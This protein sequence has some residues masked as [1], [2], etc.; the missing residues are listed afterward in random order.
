MQAAVIPGIRGIVE[1]AK[2]IG[3]PAKYAGAVS[4]V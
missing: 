2:T 1:L 4:V 3:V